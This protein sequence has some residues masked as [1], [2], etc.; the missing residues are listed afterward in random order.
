LQNRQATWDRGLISI[1]QQSGRGFDSVEMEDALQDAG[2]K[3]GLF[4]FNAKTARF[5]GSKMG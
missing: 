1:R 4:A 3:L 2:F 5:S